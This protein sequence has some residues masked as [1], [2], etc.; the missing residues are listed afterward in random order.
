MKLSCVSNHLF[1]K[2]VTR[3]ADLEKEVFQMIEYM[4]EKGDQ[5]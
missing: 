3:M 1:K 2:P 4:H 5:K